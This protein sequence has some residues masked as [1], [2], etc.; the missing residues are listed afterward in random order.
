MSD[1]DV[2]KSQEVN[3][4]DK[5]TSFKVEI[6]VP[7]DLAG[8]MDYLTRKI[9][10]AS[11]AEEIHEAMDETVDFVNGQEKVT[12]YIFDLL[13]KA[14]QA[15]LKLDDHITATKTEISEDVVRSCV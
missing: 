2:Y 12:D 8:Q 5:K 4:K 6:K 1:V 15:L 11:N 7:E 3:C 10:S 14:E 9:A 13:V